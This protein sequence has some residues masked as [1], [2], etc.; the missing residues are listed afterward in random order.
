MT[1]EWKEKG[2]EEMKKIGR[3]Y[4]RTGKG[5]SGQVRAGQ[6]RAGQG[7][8]GQGRAGQGRAGQ[9]RA[10]WDMTGTVSRVEK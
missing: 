3:H 8:A 10:E 5:R 1:E 9:G 4:D 6:G 2:W 7:R